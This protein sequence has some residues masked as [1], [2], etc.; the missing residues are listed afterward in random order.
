M[1]VESINLD[2]ITQTN[3]TIVAERVARGVKLLD[4]HMPE[5]R[6]K[7]YWQ[8]FRMD[9]IYMCILGQLFGNYAIGKNALKIEEFAGADFGFDRNI[10]E[11]IEGGP[12]YP[13]YEAA[14]LAHKNKE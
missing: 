10:F 11:K 12:D 1:Q 7:I 3:H 5:W 9:D 14:W 4:N 8:L 2:V 13:D 6:D